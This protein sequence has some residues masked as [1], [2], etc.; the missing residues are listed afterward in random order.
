MTEVPPSRYRVI[1][2]GRR[3]EVI[4][5]RAP[6]PPPGQPAAPPTRSGVPRTGAL[7]RV[8]RYDGTRAWT[9]QPWYDDRGPRQVTLMPGAVQQLLVVGAAALLVLAGLAV[10]GGLP[11]LVIV[12][13]VA[14]TAA[15]QGRPWLTRRL[16]RLASPDQP[17]EG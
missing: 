11:A 12:L 2:R 7:P 14:A 1:E 16:D 15:Q 8:V 13:M 10:I 3:L 17:S 6:T 4:D 9:T 5:T